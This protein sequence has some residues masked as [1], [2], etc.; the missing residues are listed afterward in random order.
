MASTY[1]DLKVWQLGMDLVI[2]I[3]AVSAAFPKDELY[4]LVTQMRRA[5]VSIVSNIA[6]GKGRASDK[7]LA[8]FLSNARGSLR[9]LETQLFVAGH[10]GYLN[11]SMEKELLARTDEIGRMLNSLMKFAKTSGS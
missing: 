2:K 1:R 7:E 8:Y 10:L 5:A 4:G 6:E 9:E 11:E 3:Y